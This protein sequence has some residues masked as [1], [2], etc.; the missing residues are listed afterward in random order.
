MI[1]EVLDLH[2]SGTNPD[3]I[4]EEDLIYDPRPRIWHKGARERYREWTRSE[5]VENPWGA[6]YWTDIDLFFVSKPPGATASIAVKDPTGDIVVIAY[7]LLL[8]L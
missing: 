3:E 2:P 4:T 8:R 1:E 7:D 5:I 6:I